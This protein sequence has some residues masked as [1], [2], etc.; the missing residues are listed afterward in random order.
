MK[1][2]YIVSWFNSGRNYGQTLQAY[3]LQ[4]VLRNLGYDVCHVCYA[5]NRDPRVNVKQILYKIIKLSRNQRIIQDKFDSFIRTNMMV[6]PH[7]SSVEEVSRYIDIT[8]A[9]FLICGSDQVWNP[10]NVDPVYY[11][12]GIGN[13]KT[14][15]IAYAVSTCDERRKKKFNDYPEVKKWVQEID[16]VFT[17]EKTGKKIFNELFD[18][19]AEVVLDPTLLLDREQW[20]ENMRLE[21]SDSRYVLCYAFSL[22]EKQKAIIEKTAQKLNCFVRYSNILMTKQKYDKREIWSPND[23]LDAIFNAQMVFTDSFH[24]T[25]FSVL[26][27]KEFL[28]FDN[29]KEEN[30][31]PYY[32]IDRMET[33]LY[34]IGL[35]SRLVNNDIEKLE[36]IDYAQVDLIIESRRAECIKLLRESIG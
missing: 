22:T 8:G 17:R 3:S 6:T 15:K 31:D 21:Y 1:K 10:Y 19:K 36:R 24:G 35:T 11:L 14:K 27:H 29:G 9:D 30:S 23:F 25:V 34:E 18:V 28:V 5:N 7:L 12:H 2:G 16:Y 32:N 26:F 4:K 13:S 33:F 20:I